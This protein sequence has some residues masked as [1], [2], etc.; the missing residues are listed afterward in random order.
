[1]AGKTQQVNECQETGVF[2]HGNKVHIPII[3]KNQT[4]YEMNLI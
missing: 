1:M 2:G 4:L 3:K